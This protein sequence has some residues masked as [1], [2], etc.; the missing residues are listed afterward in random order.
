MN[1]NIHITALEVE[2]LK[3]IKAVKMTPSPSG[4]TVIGG[5]NAQGKTSVLDAI[6]YALGGERYAPTNPKRDGSVVDPSI[7]L[8]LSN[9]ILVERK[10]K[11]STLKVTDPNGAR[12]GQQLLNEFISQFALDLPKFLNSSTSDKAKVLLQVIGIGDKLAEYDKR[13]KVLY[14]E[15]HAQGRVADSKQ[16]YADELPSFAD[17]PEVQQ[18][19]SD[20][21]ERHAAVLASN[22]A[23]ILAQATAQQAD[24]AKVRAAQ[25]VARLREMLASAEAILEQRTAQA[26]AAGKS[27]DAM[28]HIDPSPFAQRLT[29]VEAINAK[30]RANLEKQ[31]ALADAEAAQKQRADLTAKIDRLR[32]ERIALLDGAKLPLPGLTVIDGELAYQSQKWDCMSHSEQLRVATAIVRALKPEC[33]FVLLDKLESMDGQTLSE[34]GA[35]LQSV[36]LQAIAT[37]VSTGGECSII[38]EDGHGIQDN[39][40]SP[41]V[42]GAIKPEVTYTPGEF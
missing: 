34:F 3:R 30:V 1:E 24:D 28:Q 7:K 36:G 15:R 20:L 35:W 38:I 32:A 5:R 17:A 23:L 18:S 39:F 22:D 12:S 37:R 8:T 16:K 33:G 31:K 26:V 2:N 19:A 42:G 9:G 6:A 27:R 10:G 29:E 25:E 40:E 41:A 11:S 14:D 21:I 4:L 13:E